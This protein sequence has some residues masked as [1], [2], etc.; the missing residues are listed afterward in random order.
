MRGLISMKR[1]DGCLGRRGRNEH[2]KFIQFPHSCAKKLGQA[3]NRFATRKF[4]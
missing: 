4:L 2:F 3:G 1:M